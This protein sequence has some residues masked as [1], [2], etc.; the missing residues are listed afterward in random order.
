[1]P[2]EASHME[3]DSLKQV[4]CCRMPAKMISSIDL[5]AADG[6]ITRC[7]LIRRMLTFYID[8]LEAMDEAGQ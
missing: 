7:E 4:V 2:R 5:I 6:G 1:M 3:N 8:Y